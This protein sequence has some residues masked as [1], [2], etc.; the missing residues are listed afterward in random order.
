MLPAKKYFICK[1]DKKPGVSAFFGR[2]YI[3]FT[4]SILLA[5]VY[6]GIMLLYRIGWRSLPEW[7]VPPNWPAQTMVTILIPARNEA[8]H[9]QR[10]IHSIVNGNYPQHLLDIVVIDDFSDDDT[11]SV[12]LD[13]AREHANMPFR[14]RLLSLSKLLPPEA[15]DKANKKAAIEQ[16]IA[17]AT[18][19]LIVTTDADCIADENWLPLLISRLEQAPE[20][21][22]PPLLVTGPVLFYQEKNLLQYFQSLD[23]LGLMGITAAGIHKG[24]QR[25]GNGANLA[26]HRSVF[27]AVGGYEGNRQTASGDDMFL[28]QKIAAQFPGRV[29]FVKNAAAKVRTEAKPDWPSFVQQRLRWGTKNAVLPEWPV[30]LILLSVYLFCWSIWINLFACL[31]FSGQPLFLQILVFQVFIKIIFDFSLLREMCL[32]FDRRDLLRWFLLSFPIHTLYIPLIGTASL[33]LKKY[34]WK[35]RK[36]Q[37]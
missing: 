1:R 9:I 34:D 5:L 35:G 15:A 23:F 8:A 11:A 17:A 37:R 19:D 3:W 10:C 21:A 31:S 2:M 28:I 32:Y 7:Q 12:V 16:G 14:I 25:M 27:Q 26:Y 33:F 6:A 24:F 20:G 13:M 36:A 29:A 22:A 30:R 4:V 18:G